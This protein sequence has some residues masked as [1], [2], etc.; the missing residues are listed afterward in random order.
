L[1]INIPHI[2]YIGA[3]IATLMGAAYVFSANMYYSQKLYCV[4]HD[5]RAIAGRDI[6]TDNTMEQ[7]FSL[8]G[9]IVDKVRSFKTDSG[10]TNFCYNLFAYFNKRCFRTGKWAG[11]SPLMR[12]RFQYG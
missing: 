6:E 9:D 4:P 2:G 1:A 10:L 8:M 11:F 3:G 12:A 7:I 5:W